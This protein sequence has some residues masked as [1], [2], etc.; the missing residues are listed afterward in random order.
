MGFLWSF[1]EAVAIAAPSSFVAFVHDGLYLGP[2]PGPF[3]MVSYL[4]HSNL[5]SSRM[6]LKSDRKG[7]NASFVE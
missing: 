4:F 3:D 2:F 1:L 5:Y 6:Y 7:F